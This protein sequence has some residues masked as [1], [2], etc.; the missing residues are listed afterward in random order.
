MKGRSAP[1]R[2][3]PSARFATASSSVAPNAA[4]TPANR[5][6]TIRVGQP[7]PDTAVTADA[8]CD[9]EQAEPGGDA[10]VCREG[11]PDSVPVASVDLTC[12][13]DPGRRSPR[14]SRPDVPS[15]TERVHRGPQRRISLRRSKSCPEA[16]QAGSTKPRRADGQEDG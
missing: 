3:M 9:L 16:G 8:H 10:S 13:R 5:R 4:V 12:L 14:L 6:V 11:H 1:N 2:S 15:P 7:G